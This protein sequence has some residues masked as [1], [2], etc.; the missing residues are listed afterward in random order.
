M[1]RVVL[2]LACA[3]S[4]AGFL[5]L[6]ARSDGAGASASGTPPPQI[7]HIVTTALCARLHERV[8][9]SVAMI[10]QNDT[11]IAKSPPLFKRYQ[12]GA[13]TAL[14]PASP[15]FSNGAPP[16]GDSVYNHS[17]ETDMALQQMSYLVLP[18]ARNL[19]AAQTLLDD[20]RLVQPTGNANDDATLKKIRSQLLETIAFQSASLDL[21][22]G[23]VETQR[24]GELQ[25]AGEEY[26]AEIG[27]QEQPGVRSPIIKITPNPWQDPN[28]PGLAPNPYA[29]DPATVP[30]LSVGYNPLRHIMDG[31]QWLRTETQKREDL[32]GQTITAALAECGK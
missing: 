24:M 7:Y 3:L 4:F 31:L 1:Q 6:A 25:H 26:I 19:I 9:P 11:S 16:N 12:R 23:F 5:R 17:P 2:L 22:N 18:I 14:D 8:R 30:G 10:L 20:T 29:F 32:A 28:T 15:N 13:L 27:G 21:I